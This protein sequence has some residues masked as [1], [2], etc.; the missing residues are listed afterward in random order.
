MIIELESAFTPDEMYE[1]SCGICGDRFRCES[2]VAWVRSDNLDDM[3]RACPSCVGTMGRRNPKRFPTIEEH[4]AAKKRFPGPIWDTDRRRGPCLGDRRRRHPRRHCG[5]QR[6]SP[7]DAGKAGGVRHPRWRPQQGLRTH[8]HPPGLRRLDGRRGPRRLASRG[9][10]PRGPH[11]LL[12]GRGRAQERRGAVGG[13]RG[14][15]R[16]RGVGKPRTWP[17][18]GYHGPGPLSR[19]G[20]APECIGSSLD[21]TGVELLLF[22]LL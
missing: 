14:A 4:E 22:G 9:V 17:G 5:R 19:G 7:R 12:R 15:K 21:R 20:G 1:E 18:R 13:V 16:Q 8:H 3:N 6:D 11:A 2:I 10:H